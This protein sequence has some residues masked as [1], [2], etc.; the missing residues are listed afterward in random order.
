MYSLRCQE[1][2]DSLWNTLTADERTELETAVL[3]TF[4]TFTRKAY[5]QEKSEG[6]QGPGH[7][8]L[9]AGVNK[10]LATRRGLSPLADAPIRNL[11]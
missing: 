7:H 5:N 3:I 1:Q 11:V 8:A 10:L 2:L 4:N 6:R 9:R